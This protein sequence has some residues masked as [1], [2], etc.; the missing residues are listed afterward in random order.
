MA[1]EKKAQK[2]VGNV[3]YS[4][5]I[6]KKFCDLVA[7]GKFTIE[8][9]CSQCGFVKQ[10]FYNWKEKY[11]DFLDLYEEAEIQ[12]MDAIKEM[13]ISGLAKIV[14]VFEYEEVKQE[15]IIEKDEK[16]NLKQIPTKIIRTKKRVMPN[17]A[18]INFVLTNQD[19]IR[20]K[21]RNSVDHT[22]NGE[23]FG[24]GDFLMNEDSVPGAGPIDE[25]TEI[26]ESE[27]TE[28]NETPQ[29]TADSGGNL[30]GATFEQ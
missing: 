29:S 17:Q 7:S 19:A 27:T 4:K 22:N 14:D 11:L 15:T 18:A 9:C 23:S 2:P 16:G 8:D 6:A 24:F 21:N 25:T 26:T 10:T 28:I 5:A 13:A 1:D 12:R 3:K 20:W 30:W